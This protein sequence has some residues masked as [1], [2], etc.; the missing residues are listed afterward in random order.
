MMD[1][2]TSPYNHQSILPL[3]TLFAGSSVL[4]MVKAFEEASGKKVATQVMERRAG[5]SVAVW[6]ATNKAET[7][8]GWK[9]KYGV[10]DMC[11]HQWAWATKY[12][13]GYETPL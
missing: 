2:R 13:Q 1:Q 9:A 8:L 11:K 7:E 5:D 12:P 10:L 4:E 6:A 3:I